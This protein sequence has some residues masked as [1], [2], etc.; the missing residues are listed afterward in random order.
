[1]IAVDM[2]ADN[3]GSW[4]LH[5]HV[6]DHMEGG[7]MAV[8]TIYPTPT[9]SC[10]IKFLSGDF[11][12]SSGKFSLTVQN[13]SSKAI[14]EL[15]LTS[16]H[17]LAPQDLRR[18]FD[19]AWSSNKPLPASGQQVLEKPAYRAPS[20]QAV[21]GWVFFPSAIVYADGTTWRPKEEGKCFKTFWRDQGHPD[22]PALPP[23][24]D[25]LNPD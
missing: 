16:E 8:Y 5:C 1:M 19:S 22:M 15:T 13:A 17:F 7:M 20:A 3:P 24:Q 6:A 25:E 10:P 21:R 23:R 4:M 18:P 11:W 14:E 9:S 12:G 2:I